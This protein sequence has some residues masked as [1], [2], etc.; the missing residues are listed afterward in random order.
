MVTNDD[1]ELEENNVFLPQLQQYLSRLKFANRS[2]RVSKSNPEE[3]V[4]SL[5]VLPHT[6]PTG[7]LGE[8][9]VFIDEMEKA[10]DST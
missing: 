8:D 2:C 7:F 1:D 10:K 4:S 6:W 3:L 5:L 9:V